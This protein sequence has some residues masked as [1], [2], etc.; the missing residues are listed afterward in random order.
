M[1]GRML[2]V[3][4]L[5]LVGSAACSSTSHNSMQWLKTHQ[6]REEPVNQLQIGATRTSLI[7]GEK[8]QLS[9]YGMVGSSVRSMDR[10]VR[11]HV[12]GPG[13]IERPAEQRVLYRSTNPS[14]EQG[15]RI[16]ATL[17]P[18]KFGREGPVK[19]SNTIEIDV[20]PRDER[21][22]LPDPSTVQAGATVPRKPSSE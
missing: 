11:Y 18:S 9:A 22:D 8:S 7:A 19:K 2:V 1:K 21:I 5:L 16:Y 3:L 12:K 4:S 13:W 17:D 10:Y 15:V 6:L 14:G 20:Y